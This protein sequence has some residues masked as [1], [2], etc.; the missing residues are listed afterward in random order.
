MANLAVVENNK[1]VEFYDN[2]PTNWKNISNINV[3]DINDEAQFVELKK[4]G[5]RKIVK[6]AFNPETHHIIVI[7]YEY[8]I[9]KD[10]VKEKLLLRENIYKYNPTGP[11]NEEQ[12]DQIRIIRDQMMNDCEWRYTRS[13]RHKRLGLPYESIEDLDNYMQA[14]ADITKQED[15]YRVVWPTLITVIIDPTPS[16]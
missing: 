11:S 10:E 1:I 12:W 6:Q 3:Y 5:W 8:D 14:L 4:L 13:E 2:L 7:N 9:E 15:P 16:E